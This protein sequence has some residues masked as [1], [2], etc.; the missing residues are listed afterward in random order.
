MRGRIW[1]VGDHAFDLSRQGLIMGVLNVTPDS[2]SDGGSFFPLEKA[3]E[4]GLRMAAEGAD[5]I[6]IGGE[7]TRPGAEPIPSSEE[8]RRVIRVI[9]KLRAKIDIPISIDTS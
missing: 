1:K 3:M 9:E 8:L 6:D 5:I 7:S 4:H 2:F